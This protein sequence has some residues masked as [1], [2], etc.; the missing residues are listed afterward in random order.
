MIALYK[1]ELRALLPLLIVIGLL[2]GADFT[3]RPLDERIDEVSWVDQSS[4][5]SPGKG[6][7]ELAIIF[8]I[9]AL[10]AAYSV[11]PRE[12]DEKT[13]EFL[14]ALPLR[15]SHIFFAKALAAWTVLMFGVG[16]EILAG[17][18]FQ[19]LNP[20]SFSGEQWRFELAFQITLLDGFYCA[21]I[22]CHG[23][24]ISFLR[25][26][27]L[28]V[29]L[30]IAFAVVLIKKHLPSY[31][32]LDPNELLA[33]EY[34]GS[35]LVIPWPDLLF[36]GLVALVTGA[37]A[38]AL[39]M[40]AAERGSR[41]YGR[42][43]SNRPGRVALGCV[44]VMIFGVG[45]VGLLMLAEDTEEPAPVRYREFLP[46]RASSTWYDFTYPS[47]LGGRARELIREADQAYEAVAAALEEKEEVF[48][49]DADLTDDGA[50]H[51]GIAQGGV[52]RVAL[53]S[54]SAEEAL[55][56]LYHETV[57]AFQF[58]LAGRKANEYSESLRFFVEG[59]AEYVSRQLRPD[60]E[61][62]RAHRRLA[63][64]AFDRHDLRFEELL[65]DTEFKTTYDPNLVYVLGETWTSAL[66]EVCGNGIVG[67]FFRALDRDD[68]PEDLAGIALWQDAL[69]AS[70]CALEPVVA[71]WNQRMSELV[72]AEQSFLD[73]LPRLGGGVV[74]QGEVDLV[75]ELQLDR[76]VERPAETYYLRVRRDPSVPDDQVRTFTAEF[77]AD[78]SASAG[79]AEFRVPAAWFQGGSF[80]CQFGQSIEGSL[81]AFFEEWQVVSP[82]P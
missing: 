51:L 41:F 21:L 3:Y 17:G 10:I 14:Y 54:L 11:F 61:Q 34:Q 30:V 44:S 31:A 39:W 66:A 74:E 70:N 82:G 29:Y 36:H 33:L 79:G 55:Y 52:I 46:A 9:F 16:L 56:T 58:Q 64:A 81:W 38:Y 68:A 18:V 6:K 7:E 37:L 77:A 20:Q 12:H 2:F 60:P 50:G 40:G 22:L 47:N 42:L 23:L 67:R 24:L 69:R 26:L 62:R 80:E 13:I 27:G 4:Q 72:T 35:T 49:I 28:L 19:A 75:I 15:R 8:M 1:K 48:R 65:D 63:A 5:L 25:R 43:Q 32:F 53:E 57:H 45:F 78:S 71:R 59:S 73:A 76:A